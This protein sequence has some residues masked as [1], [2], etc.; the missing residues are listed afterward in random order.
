LTPHKRLVY[1]CLALASLVIITY[2]GVWHCDFIAYDD[3]SHVY[4]NDQV[5]TGLTWSNVVWAFTHWHASQWIPLTWISHMIDV[6]LFGLDP[7]PHH[8]VNVG[9]HLANVLLLFTVLRRMTGAFWQSACVAALFAVHPLNVESVAWIAERKNV[10]NTAFWLLAI[11][12]YALYAQKKDVRWLI[13]TTLCMAFGLMTKA[14]IVTLPFALL[15]FDIWPLQRWSLAALP[16]LVAE[17]IPLFLISAAGCWIQLSIGAQSGL[18]ENREQ[19]PILFRLACVSANYLQ[20]LIDVFLPVTLALPYPVPHEAPVV[21]AWIG[22]GVF[23]VILCLAWRYR[24]AS[25]HLLI[26]LLWFMGILVPVVGAVP[27]GDTL[28]ANRYAYV[29]QIGLFVAVVWTVNLFRMKWAW[30][31]NSFLAAITITTF[32]ILS[33]RYVSRWKDTVALFTYATKILPNSYK[34]YAIVGVVMVEKRQFQEAVRYFEMSLRINPADSRTRTDLGLALNQ[35][36]DI[37]GAIVQLRQATKDERIGSRAAIHFANVLLQP[38]RVEHATEA[39][40]LLEK[41]TA[42]HVKTSM[43]D[44]ALLAGSSQKGREIVLEEA[45]AF[46]LLGK[47]CDTSSDKTKA[48][49]AYRNALMLVPWDPVFKEAVRKIEKQKEKGL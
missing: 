47:A 1:V 38:G 16:K 35:L 39:V 48:E 45:L 13:A 33:F 24:Q 20:Y 46:Y 18:L 43:L 25:P 22:L 8:L 37:A 30:L 15:L 14:M 19:F 11:W 9:F 40:A 26:G 12:C 49:L 27:A 10:L 4:E 44:T 17:K 32:F 34:A 3:A 5:K 42:S 31:M 29:P 28:F 7:G 41:V 21:Q 23:G 2:S 6:S 36:G